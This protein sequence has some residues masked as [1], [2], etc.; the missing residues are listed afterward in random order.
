V[1][2]PEA[3]NAQNSTTAVSAESRTVWHLDPPTLNYAMRQHRA[4]HQVK[5]IVRTMLYP[6]PENR[7]KVDLSDPT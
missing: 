7:F 1:I 6:A 5:R 4:K 2:C 3:S